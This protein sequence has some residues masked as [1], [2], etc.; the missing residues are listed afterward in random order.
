PSVR[1]VLEALSLLRRRYADHVAVI[2]KVMGPWTLSYHVAGVEDFLASIILAPDDVRR[3]LDVLKEVTIMF[4]R[5]QARA[6]ADAVVVADHATGDL[7]SP[8]TYRD[9]LLPIHREIVS[10]VGCPMILHICGDNTDRLDYF[11]QA[12]FDGYHFESKVDAVTAVETVRGRMCLIGNINNPSTLL[13][14][15]PET[16]RAEAKAAILAGVDI[17]APECAVPL[18]VPV[19]NLRAITEAAEEAAGCT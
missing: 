10:R 5:A 17:L 8:K 1:V 19:A 9:F 11:V 18:K 12:G 14:G 4:A 13:Y 2:G 16:V 7:I 3:Y 6:G 15:T